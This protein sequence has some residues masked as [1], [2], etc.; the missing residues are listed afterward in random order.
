[1]NSS[2]ALTALFTVAVDIPVISAMCTCVGQQMP[3]SS[4]NEAIAS[5]VVQ[6]T[7]LKSLAI[8]DPNNKEYNFK[9]ISLFSFIIVRP[10]KIPATALI[11]RQ[12][13]IK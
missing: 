2:K 5:N 10:S 9:K 11:I 8:P 3:L 1:L 13:N 6:F 12:E 7:G 4:M